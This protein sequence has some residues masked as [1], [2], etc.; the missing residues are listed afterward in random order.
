MK[1]RECSVDKKA[2]SPVFFG[3][4][5]ANE[6]PRLCTINVSILEQLSREGH[7]R[8]KVV[9]QRRSLR[10]IGGMQFNVVIGKKDIFS[11]RM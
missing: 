10:K 9:E 2:S 7:D 3:F 1:L 5:S 6:P 8:G 4:P 11:F